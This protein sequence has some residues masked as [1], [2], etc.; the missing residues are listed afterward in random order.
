MAFVFVWMG[1][2][3]VVMVAGEALYIG[4][5]CKQQRLEAV[6]YHHHI[7]ACRQSLD[8]QLVGLQKAPQVHG[9]WESYVRARVQ[10]VSQFGT[11]ASLG[12]SGS[13]SV[14][15]VSQLSRPCEFSNSIM[16]C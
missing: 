6:K 7:H 13:S 2:F 8:L 16:D 4:E 12:W 14:W 10:E 11:L 9:P 15:W 5:V 3:S 1:C